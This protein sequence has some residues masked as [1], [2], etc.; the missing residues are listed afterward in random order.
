MPD[1]S[2][3]H[4]NIYRILDLLWDTLENLWCIQ[5]IN[6]NDKPRIKTGWTLQENAFRELAGLA[7]NFPNARWS[8][9][10]R[11]PAQLTSTINKERKTILKSKSNGDTCHYFQKFY[12]HSKT[13]EQTRYLCSTSL[14]IKLLP[15]AENKFMQKNETSYSIS[16]E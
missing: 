12:Y 10:F 9:Q 3:I 16:E 2:I 13:S 7:E 8:S 14:L 1:L 5:K 4:K 15:M 6:L 11:F